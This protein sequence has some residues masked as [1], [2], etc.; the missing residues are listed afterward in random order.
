MCLV[1]RAAQVP[2]YGRFWVPIEDWTNIKAP[3]LMSERHEN[4]FR[5]ECEDRTCT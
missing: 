2:A 4:G 1:F 5:P 3:N